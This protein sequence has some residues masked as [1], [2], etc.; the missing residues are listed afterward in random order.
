[1]RFLLSLAGLMALTPALIAEESSRVRVTPSE[2]ELLGRFDRA[3][4]VVTGISTS[5]GK[6][7]PEYYRDLTRQAVYDSESSDVVSVDSTGLVTAKRAGTALI[8]VTLAGEAA[9]DILEIPVRV[10]EEAAAEIDF[11]KDVRPI[12][13]KAG[14]AA[15]ACHASQHG[16]GGFKLSVFGYD[17]ESDYDAI[18]VSSRGRRVSPTQPGASLILDKATMRV[19]H[20]GG[21]RMDEESLEYALLCQWIGNGAPNSNAPELAV[22]HLDVF[23]DQRVDPLGYSQQLRVIASYSDGTQRDV[24]PLAIYDAIDSGILSVSKTGHVKTVGAGQSAVMVRYDGQVAVATFVVP[25]SEDARLVDW[26]NHNYIDEL[27]ARKFLDLGLEPS[28][29]CDDATFIRRAFLDA[30]GSLPT[31]ELVTAFIESNDEHKREQLIDRLLGLTGDPTQDI[32]NER[33]A[34]FWTLRWSDLIRNNSNSLGEQGMW[35]MHNWIRNSLRANKPFDQFVRELIT[36]QGSIYSNGPA[37]YFRVHSDSSA[38]TE[39]TAQLFMGVR[40]ECAKCHQHPFESISQSDYYSM[41]AFFARV[42]SKNSEEFGLF[43]RETVIMVKPTGEV[44]HPRTRQTLAP[45][46]LGSEPLEDPLDRRI[47]L[48]DW[49]TSADN[50]FFAKSVANRYVGYLLGSGLVE[51]VDDMRSTNP[52]SNQALLDAITQDFIDHDFDLKH[53]I[54][55]IMTSRL[56]SLSSQPNPGNVQDERFFSHFIVKRIAAEPLLDAIDQA[57]GVQTK[58]RNLPLGTLAIELPDA[59]Y[60]DYFLNV[61]A[62]PRRVSVCECER[63]P[64]ANLAQALHT[65][66]GDTITGKIAAQNG[67]IARLIATKESHEQIVNDI[68][69]AALCRPPS[70][71]E[72]DASHEILAE[73]SN[74]TE[75]YQD[76]LWALLNTK[77]FLFVH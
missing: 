63:A 45:K 76:L 68:Y 23:P 54:R 11:L 57:S 46:P 67:R 42:G 31:P 28:G 40:L 35:A 24:T 33:Y 7:G 74:A 59:E 66:N 4:M 9:P 62:K 27:A 26:K 70:P 21:L 71:A 25:Y 50:E 12:L 58:F 19:A 3:Q 14:C 37:N 41:S 65:L 44:T 15:A 48:A 38:L 75:C 17:P 53:L 51:P 18:A 72:R 2:I 39:A 64:D 69:L 73:Y 55:T 43:G 5:P 20:G 29:V 49:L 47:P 61:F 30:I 13:S 56:Y 10:T 36:A 52:P 60:P 34:A 8:R 32:F 77:Q 6:S 1:M 22:T 16:K